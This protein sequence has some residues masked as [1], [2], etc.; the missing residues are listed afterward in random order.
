[1]CLP[2]CNFQCHCL[3]SLRSTCDLS[4]FSQLFSCPRELN[5][6]DLFYVVYLFVCNISVYIPCSL[7]LNKNSDGWSFSEMAANQ[8]RT[9]FF[10][11]ILNT[12]FFLMRFS[13]RI[14]KIYIRLNIYQIITVS[15]LKP[16]YCIKT[17][18]H[19]HESD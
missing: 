7:F 13:Y 11:D 4:F 12:Q 9:M 3:F 6:P 18:M 14:F 16:Y 10:I 15:T 2:V 17:Q 19:I 8:E 1:M 5:L